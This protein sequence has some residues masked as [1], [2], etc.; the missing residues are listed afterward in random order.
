MFSFALK[1]VGKQFEH[2]W[3]LIWKMYKTLW[4]KISTSSMNNFKIPSTSF[5]SNNLNQTTTSYKFGNEYGTIF[6]WV[7]IWGHERRR[8][9]FFIIVRYKLVLFASIHLS[10]SNLG[11]AFLINDYCCM[12]L[13]IFVYL[14]KFKSPTICNFFLNY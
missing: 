12:D 3:D 4:S 14:N 13:W 2:L 5:W 9:F 7:I 6:I 1:D 11:T 8:K 10:V